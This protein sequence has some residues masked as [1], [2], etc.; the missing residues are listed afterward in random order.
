MG[1]SAFTGKALNVA[2]NVFPY[3]G[4][5]ATLLSFRRPAK[6]VAQ[7]LGFALKSTIGEERFRAV[8]CLVLKNCENLVL[9]PN[10]FRSFGRKQRR[11]V[12]EYFEKT[13]FAPQFGPLEAF[14]FP[15]IAKEAD[16]RRL[17]LFQAVGR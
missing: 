6:Q 2:L 17:N 12:S 13:T 3:E 1:D 16:E 11:I 9:R 4:R 8:S 10:L 14:L 7:N 5:Q 15:R